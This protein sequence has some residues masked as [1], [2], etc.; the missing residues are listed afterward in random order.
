MRTLL[1]ASAAVLSFAAFVT[2][3]TPSVSARLWL[4]FCRVGQAFAV[5]VLCIGWYMMLSKGD[6][7]IGMVIGKNTGYAIVVTSSLAL[8][9]LSVGAHVLQNSWLHTS[10]KTGGGGTRDSDK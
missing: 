7:G 10:S 9:A 4:S 8:F 6:G 5:F 2:M 1:W 3:L